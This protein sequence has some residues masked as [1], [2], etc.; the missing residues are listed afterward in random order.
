MSQRSLLDM[1]QKKTKK[2]PKCGK[3]RSKFNFHKNKGRKDGL[4]RL[5]KKCT[6][7][8]FRG[9]YQ[10]SP[11]A[12]EISRKSN[13]KMRYGLTPEQHKQK[14]IEQN[15]CCAVCKKAIAYKDV[16][17]DHEYKTGKVRKLLCQRCNVA[18]GCYEGWFMKYKKVVLKYLKETE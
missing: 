17:T 15:G 11:R 18:L 10:K 9:Y 16:H 3:N 12:Y 2:C 5:C 7:K 8:Y 13:L 1:K 6:N 4:A 14:Y